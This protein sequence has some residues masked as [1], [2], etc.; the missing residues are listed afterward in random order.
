MFVSFSP[1]SICVPVYSGKYLS[2]SNDKYFFP[3]LYMA[4]KQNANNMKVC[5]T[6]PVI[7]KRQ[8]LN[9]IVQICNIPVELNYT[10]NYVS[11]L[12]YYGKQCRILC[13]TN[14]QAIYHKIAVVLFNTFLRF[15]HFCIRA[16]TLLNLLFYLFQ[17]M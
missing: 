8:I 6:K 3:T 5:G 7:V 12:H 14:R 13:R 11:C 4:Y 17:Y 9:N 2:S 10:I 1:S 15:G 16:K